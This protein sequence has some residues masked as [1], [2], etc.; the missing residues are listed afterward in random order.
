MKKLETALNYTIPV[1]DIS[2]HISLSPQETN[3]LKV[4][5][6][7]GLGSIQSVMKTMKGLQKDNDKLMDSMY[8]LDMQLTKCLKED[9]DAKIKTTIKKTLREVHKHI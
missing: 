5:N 9:D 4:L 1:S 8:I 6:G 2:P 7:V 3:S